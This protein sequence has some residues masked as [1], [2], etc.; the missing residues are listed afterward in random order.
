LL[1]LFVK[2]PLNP[3][4]DFIDRLGRARALELLPSNFSS[5]QERTLHASILNLAAHRVGDETLG[6]FALA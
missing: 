6:D 5:C 2:A 3:V 1:T 4:A